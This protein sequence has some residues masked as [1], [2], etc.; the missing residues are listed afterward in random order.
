MECNIDEQG[1]RFRRVWGVMVLTAGL[2]SGG[3]AFWS[4]I[5]WMWI[6]AGVCVGAGGFAIFESRKK[7]CALRA[8]GVKTRI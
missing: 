7:W 6:I 4:G 3:L 2:I 1:V 8:M 5:W